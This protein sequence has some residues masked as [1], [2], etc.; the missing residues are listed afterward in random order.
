[1]MPE[2][3]ATLPF[4]L[5]KNSAV[6]G[7][8]P[9][10][11]WLKE[12]SGW[13]YKPDDP[14]RPHKWPGRTLA[15]A[16]PGAAT[17]LNTKG[18]AHLQFDNGSNKVVVAANSRF[19]EATDGL[20][21]GAFTTAKDAAAADFVRT[22]GTFLKAISD[23]KNR[24]IVWDGAP[25]TR[26]LVRDEDGT[27]RL[28]S[29]KKASPV[30]SAS[31]IGA[32]PTEFRPDR[33]A[34]ATGALTGFNNPANAYDLSQTTSASLPIAATGTRGTMWDF[35]AAPG[36]APADTTGLL[37]QL[38]V[39]TSSLPPD[40]DFDPTG[41]GA[42]GTT[43][44]L[45]ASLRVRVSENNGGA[46]TTV[47]QKAVPVGTVTIQ[48]ALGATIWTDL[49]VEVVLIYSGGTAQVIPNVYE[50][51]VSSGGNT[52]AV[53]AGTYHYSIVEQWTI[54]LASGVT[55]LVRGAP[56]D[57]FTIVVGA[58]NFGVSLS[59]PTLNNVP[60]DGYAAVKVVREI[61]RS[62]ST[63]AYPDLGKIG[64]TA[65]TVF[66]DNF[67]TSGST[68][69]LPSLRTVSVNGA[70]YPTDGQCP[71]FRDATLYK[72]AIVAIPEDN[73]RTVQYSMPGAPDSWPL[74]VHDLS[75]L[76][77][78]RN[79]EGKGIVTVGDVIL[80]FLRTRVLRLRD[81]PFAD[82]PNF[83]LG[84]LKVDILS[85]NEGLA[86]GPRGYTLFN[87]QDGSAVV[88]WVS[89]NGLWMTDGS[90]PSERGMGARKISSHLN[91][92]KEV[93]VSALSSAVLTYDPVSQE[94]FLDCTAP[95]GSA[96]TLVFNVAPP[97]W[98][99]LTAGQFVPKAADA[100]S[101]MVAQFRIIG[102]TS[103][104][105]RHWSLNTADLNVYS[106]RNGTGANGASI[107][108]VLETGWIYPAGERN[109][110]T[111]WRSSLYHS[112]WGQS[113]TCALEILTRR[114][115]RGIEQHV[116]KHPSLRGERVTTKMIGRSGQALKARVRHHGKTVSDGSSLRA[117]GPLTLELSGV[118]AVEAA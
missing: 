58:G 101:N 61:Y 31:V 25:N 55:F 114:D 36:G 116:L 118:N 6:D 108:S 60:A 65:S 102:E 13:H 37:L 106:E 44:A 29:M 69:G 11:G 110:W 23:G 27:W 52:S 59:L 72:G 74:P 4:S 47:F 45:N 113:E 22:G 80:L 70:F 62:T 21:L 42:G 17:A 111:A 77:L 8:R 81:L 49:Q 32:F 43:E 28:L 99:P 9:P 109:E 86:A 54:T 103:G 39:G 34:T 97:H 7:L 20:T 78:E 66:D 87:F 10:P 68:L 71:A 82:R 48:Y 5:G 15:A 90:L 79:E 117:I 112:D 98:V 57:P 41:G 26:P 115:R 24:S 107:L 76:P 84:T 40:V 100:P 92:E 19:Y 53:T 35:T 73:P 33:S 83:D 93:L 105:L 104:V 96:K 30:A 88:A 16:L 63:G 46:W 67:V 56:S 38:R 89:D 91:W 2:Q 18:I 75:T 50:I 64:E 94:L 3:T 51:W 1:M 85:P 95:D 12:F 14:D